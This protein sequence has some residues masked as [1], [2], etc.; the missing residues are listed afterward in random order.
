[1][2][3]GVQQAMLGTVTGNEALSKLVD[4]WRQRRNR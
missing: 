2:K 3:T 4:E 1:M